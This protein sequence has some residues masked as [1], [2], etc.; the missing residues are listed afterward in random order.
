MTSRSGQTGQSIDRI[1]LTNP[2][3]LIHTTN[4]YNSKS[5][6]IWNWCCCNCNYSRGN[7]IYTNYYQFKKLCHCSKCYNKSCW[8]DTNIGIGSTAQA[9]AIIN[10]LGELASI[11]YS[12]LQ[13]L[14][15]LQ[16][17]L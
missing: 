6:C 12:V 7:I 9:I 3:L 11:R 4:N 13:V 16:L 5:K 10:T 8:I 15:T 2:A 1:E 14:D 17:Q